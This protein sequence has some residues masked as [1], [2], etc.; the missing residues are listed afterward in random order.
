M[1]RERRPTINRDAASRAVSG[2][3]IRRPESDDDRTAGARPESFPVSPHPQRRV[4]ES[5][6]AGDSSH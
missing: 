2:A 1:D 4:W 5:E 6:V 3:L